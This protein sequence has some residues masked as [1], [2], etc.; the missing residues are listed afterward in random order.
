MTQ[1]MA[2]R[3]IFCVDGGGT[4]SRARLLTP[5]GVAVATAEAG[6]CN[7]TSDI[8]A[9]V[10]SVADL[11][12]SVSA[13]A[14]GLT[15]ADPCLAI[16]AAGAVAPPVRDRFLAA[17]PSF[18]EKLLMSDGYAALIGA[19]GG[20]P[21][22]LVILGT[23]AVAHRLLPDGASLQRD[24]WGWI[25]GDRGSA[26]WVGRKAVRAALAARDRLH[27]PTPLTQ[28]VEKALGASE[29]AILDWLAQAG[30]RRLA[31]LAPL[32][33]DSAAAGDM[34][35]SGILDRAAEHG[36]ALA[37]SL[38]LAPD[39]PLYLAGG[40]AEVL[41]GRIEARLGRGFQRPLGDAI[42]GCRLVA[43][44]KAPLERRP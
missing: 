36:A 40:I 17:L 31:S 10:G 33:T 42:D 43:T 29:A 26:A 4:R 21:G 27:E 37:E 34:L 22:G 44:G 30:P 28:W 39:E 7:P 14:G 1:G 20:A 25:G 18:A 5:G 3:L 8:E 16:G 6:P 24:G 35:A 15:P 13:A 32:V 2:E 19:S 41:R 23:G 9:A 12:S 11:W 38:D